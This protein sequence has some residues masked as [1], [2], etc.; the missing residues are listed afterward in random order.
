MNWFI[1][2]PSHWVYVH[3]ENGDE[4]NVANTD[5]LTEKEAL[6]YKKMWDKPNNKIIKVTLRDNDGKIVDWYKFKKD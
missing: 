1:G 4:D 5:Y 6:E 2:L 3:Y